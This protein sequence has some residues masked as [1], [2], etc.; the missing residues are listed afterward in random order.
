MSNSGK[1]KREQKRHAASRDAI[2]DPAV[3]KRPHWL[4]PQ[5][6]APDQRQRGLSHSPNLYLMTPSA[7]R[8]FGA[9]LVGAREIVGSE[10]YEEC[11][12]RMKR[13]NKLVVANCLKAAEAL[14]ALRMRFNDVRDKK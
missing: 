12:R 8:T 1:Y 3:G 5:Q 13:S 7:D 10:R 14:A 9:A 4:E 2:H 6:A 11:L